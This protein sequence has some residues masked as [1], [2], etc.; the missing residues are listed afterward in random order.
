MRKIIA[1]A[2]LLISAIYV[3]YAGS[4]ASVQSGD[5]ND[6]ATWGGAVPG[7]GDDV[8]VSHDVTINSSLVVNSLTFGQA[9]Y[10]NPDIGTLVI[11]SNSIVT[12]TTGETN[13]NRS[14]NVLTVEEGSS[15]VKTSGDFKVSAQA[16]VAINGGVEVQ[17]GDFTVSG[18][19]NSTLI[20]AES[21]SLAVSG[22]FTYAHSNQTIDI[23]GNVTVGS[24]KAS[25]GSGTTFNIG[26]TA[27]F[28]IT[29]ALTIT[30]TQ[31]FL[32]NGDFNIGSVSVTGGS[33]IFEIGEGGSMN[34]FGNFDL[35]SSGGLDI[36]AGSGTVSVGG[37]MNIA[38]GASANVDG[39]LAVDGN[40]SIESDGNRITG[41]GSVSATTADC[42]GDDCGIGDEDEVTSAP[43]PAP[44]PEDPSLP[45]ELMSF[46]LSADQ[47]SVS[48]TWET[49]TEINNDRF[50]VYR[51][52]DGEDFELIYTVDGHGTTNDIQRYGY[53]DYPGLSGVY[54]YQLEQV[55]YDGKNEFFNVKQVAFGTAS[56]T[57]N[58]TIYPVPLSAN[59]DFYV[60]YPETNEVVTA[61]IYDL[62]G[63]LSLALTAE[64]QQNRIRF[65]SA[66]LG[67]QSGIYI[68][69]IQVGQNI[70]TQ[71]I[72]LQ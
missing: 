61:K 55:D 54:F 62:S 68:V 9:Y 33:P 49:A 31:S 26:S 6:P 20:V 66:E 64:R 53:T 4:I 2:I 32:V 13:L 10:P 50:N 29:N 23:L 11:G 25:G 46:V 28:T 59:E 16:T 47:N 51:S 27:T 70:T 44:E 37:D 39:T 48:I 22:E 8:T 52:D 43:A 18:G 56:Q 40:L 14:G 24:M 35:A 1:T 57:Q 15:L 30:T 3:G 5:W 65:M 42:P 69:Q 36:S 58:L 12:V 72:R 38:G 67:L 34:V 71:K 17:N 19:N 45:V 63:S 7:T 60:S 21:G 41:S